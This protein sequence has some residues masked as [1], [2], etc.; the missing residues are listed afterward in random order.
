M[1]RRSLRLAKATEEP[2]ERS[3]TEVEDWVSLNVLF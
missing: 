3:E 2:E 1:V